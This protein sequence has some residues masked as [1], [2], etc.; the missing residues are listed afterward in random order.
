MAV[1]KMPKSVAIV[2]AGPAGIFSA[3]RLRQLGVSNITLIE[4][5][6]CVG[7]K[8]STFIDP[9]NLA[10]KA[11]RGAAVI[12][13]NYGEVIDALLEKEIKTES[14]LGAKSD[15]IEFINQMNSVNFFQRTKIGV[16]LLWEIS[17][18]NRAVKLYR[19]CCT[20]L[21]PIPPDLEA[22]F[23]QFAK[24]KN[25]TYINLLLKPLVAGFGYGDMQDCPTYSILEYM[26]YMTIPI[27]IA[28]H[29]GFQ[30]CSLRNIDGGFQF[31]MQKLAEDFNVISSANIHRI[32]RQGSHTTIDFT[33]LDGET[34]HPTEKTLQAE[35]LILA[36]SP[37]H[38]ESLFGRE[39]LTSVEQNCIDHLTY[40]RYP[41]VIC[42]LHGLPP[43]HVFKPEM[44]NREHF[45]HVAFVS[46][47]D[48]RENPIGGRL[49][50]AYINQL[51]HHNKDSNLNEGSIEL[52][53]II[54]D[55]QSLPEVTAAEIIECKIWEDYFPCLPW[56]IR[57]ELEKQQ[58]ASNTQTL[59]VGS[60]ALGSFEDVA[61]IAN[62]AT[63]VINGC[64]GASPS[65]TANL[66]KDILRFFK[67]RTR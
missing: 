15:T 31:L 55:L 8:C 60:Y 37:G 16:Q 18:F 5:E 34:G 24:Q 62:R 19:K 32:T 56:Q 51:P 44:L 20:H 48:K 39:N 9:Q 57:L 43:L 54:T 2:G 26:G 28:Q 17:K 22:P 3:R 53:S 59:Y 1:K 58:Y 12:V 46:T 7:G 14:I 30:S 67:T 27:L 40:Y 49:C 63:H 45:G 13:P 33:N 25:L 29:L 64:F 23:A 38:W 47:L 6:K 66:K 50:S 11:E 65:S 4:K 10:L 35:A 36:V 41:V 42:R 52:Q 61:C 21:Q